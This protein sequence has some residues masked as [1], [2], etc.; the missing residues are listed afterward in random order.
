MAKDNKSK[1]IAS[2]PKTVKQPRNKYFTH[3]E[4]KLMLIEAWARDGVIDEQI[5]SNLGIAY[6]TF[7]VYRDKHE[8]L[9]AA[10]KNSKEVAD[11]KV[12]SKLFLNTQGQVVKIKKPIKVQKKYYNEENG[13]LSRIEEEIVYVDEEQ[14][15]PPH[16]GAQTFW[17]I[18]RSNG[19]WK[20]TQIR[21]EEEGN[22]ETNEILKSIASQ[23]SSNPKI[24]DDDLADLGD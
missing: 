17:L 18:N 10:L 11:A 8:A 24:N 16:F 21:Y 20:N 13:K 4:P 19:K 12:E 3:V 6:S 23:L 22:K 15:I 5:A 7:R 2:K 1:K 14:Y 9:S